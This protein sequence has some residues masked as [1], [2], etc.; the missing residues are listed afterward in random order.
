MI[1][2]LWRW[3]TEKEYRITDTWNFYY[4]AESRCKILP[5]W[6]YVRGTMGKTPL[7]AESNLRLLLRNERFPKY[8]QYLG[9]ED[10]IIENK[11]E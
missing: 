9:S 6:C 11:N 5:F 4:G 10:A 3:L 2:R 1:K 8:K 7:E